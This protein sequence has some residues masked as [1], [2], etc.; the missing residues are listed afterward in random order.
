MLPS[1]LTWWIRM[2]TLESEHSLSWAGV[3][4][5]C[6]PLIQPAKGFIKFSPYFTVKNTKE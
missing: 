6:S 5:V 4:G 1:Y 2:S 3:V